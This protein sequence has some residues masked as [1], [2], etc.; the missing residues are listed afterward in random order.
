M[1]KKGILKTALSVDNER[2]ELTLCRDLFK[3]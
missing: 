2:N 3:N 1:F